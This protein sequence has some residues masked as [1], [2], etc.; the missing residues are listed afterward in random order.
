MGSIDKYFLRSRQIVSMIL[1]M[2]CV[3]LHQNILRFVH[4]LPNWYALKSPNNL[5]KKLRK[6]LGLLLLNIDYLLITIINV[7][8]NAI[9]I[10]I[11]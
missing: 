3:C 4:L 7:T 8:F 5:V 6:L 11:K 9:R 1:L 2:N 10:T